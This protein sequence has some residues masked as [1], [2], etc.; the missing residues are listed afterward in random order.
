MKQH[1]SALPALAITIVAAADRLFSIS[2][3]AAR[4]TDIDQ[5][6]LWWVGSELLRGRLHALHYPGQ[7][8]GSSA[9]GWLAGI[10]HL[11]GAGYPLAAPL[12]ASLLALVP[13]WLLAWEA[14]QRL[15][16]VTAAL[17]A[18]LPLLMTPEWSMV[19]SLTRGWL[20]GIALCGIGLWAALRA[21]RT[22]NKWSLR[23]AAVTL[24]LAVFWNVSS[25]ALAVP[26]AAWLIVRF[27]HTAIIPLALAS[28]PFAAAPIWYRS[29]PPVFPDDPLRFDWGLFSYGTNNRIEAVLAIFAPWHFSP[30][31][32]VAV[33][34]FAGAWLFSERETR[35][36]GGVILVALT[37]GYL[38]LSL[39]SI[40]AYNGLPSVFYN[41][42]RAYLWLPLLYALA[43]ISLAQAMELGF[44]AR[45][46]AWIVVS[47][48]LV[49]SVAGRETTWDYR[50]SLRSGEESY[51]GHDTVANVAKRCN[52]LADEMHVKG[53]QVHVIQGRDDFLA[54][55]CPPLV[56]AQTRQTDHDRRYIP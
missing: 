3:F 2:A 4:Y 43:M 1:A 46:L 26:L 9:E 19:T 10:W 31:W 44:P 34:F 54:Y 40:S 12:A 13:F 25:A 45:R 6:V 39:T 33:L 18:A 15:L 41:F 8:Y 37:A 11:F 49:F 56:G 29:H 28:L 21:H 53:E 27:R 42:G 48:W 38:S 35:W 5:V 22:A 7:S 32:A 17:I 51:I 24:P 50:A 16:P 14:H 52:A 36:P 30:W 23:L 47:G 20:P 55:A